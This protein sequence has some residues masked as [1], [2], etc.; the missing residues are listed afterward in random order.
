V[1][2]APGGERFGEPK[3]FA[4][5]IDDYLEAVAERSHG[6]MH[7]GIHDLAVHAGHLY[8]AYGDADRNLGD[9]RPATLR[10]LPRPDAT[11]AVVELE[12]PE[13]EFRHLRR[14][15]GTL[16]APGLDA[17]GQGFGARVYR[18]PY[19][20]AWQTSADLPG[21]VHVEDVAPFEGAL[22]AAG[23]GGR[24]ENSWAGGL[25]QALLWRSDDGGAH[26]RVAV[27]GSAPD[28][29]GEGG[30]SRF[31]RLLV[32]GR[33]LFVFGYRSAGGA[34]DRVLNGAVA[35][36]R[37]APLGPGDPLAGVVV[38]EAD[39]VGEGRA[40]LRGAPSL[41]DH[42]RAAWLLEAAGPPRR[43]HAF[44]GRTVADVFVHEPSGEVLLLVIDGD[45]W[46]RAPG[47]WNGVLYV[48]R[49]FVDFHEVVRLPSHVRPVCVA[50][51]EGRLFFGTVDGALW[52]AAPLP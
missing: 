52:R 41:Q 14:Y 30:T 47:A 50:A 18:R 51:W 22:W 31:H 20:G 26:F 12:P 38:A 4:R 39:A 11:R 7:T 3:P 28:A 43:L 1:E 9:V 45:A 19:G 2:T 23:T 40:V 10:Y 16:F 5:P 15:D 6:H 44:D 13:H 37:F 46:P 32:A 29:G 33:R 34:P 48:T 24:D 27:R 25:Q 8:L 49:D 35:A 17:V 21:G 36:G 42:R